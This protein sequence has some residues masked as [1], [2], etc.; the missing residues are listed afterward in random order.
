MK[1]Q[2]GCNIIWMNCLHSFSILSR[3]KRLRPAGCRPCRLNNSQWRGC[4]SAGPW[5]HGPPLPGCQWAEL[6]CPRHGICC[7]RGCRPKALWGTDY[8]QHF[9]EWWEPG[10]SSWCL[11]KLFSVAVLALTDLY[12][13]PLIWL[14]TRSEFRVMKKGFCDLLKDASAGTMCVVWLPVWHSF[15]IREWIKTQKSLTE[16]RTVMATAKNHPNKHKFLK[17]ELIKFQCWQCVWILVLYNKA[18]LH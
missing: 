5:T 7:L 11:K 18:I 13:S 3:N 17:C 15:L 6:H 9:W 16:M 14:C 1:L 8:S 12:F 10:R 2:W 4:G